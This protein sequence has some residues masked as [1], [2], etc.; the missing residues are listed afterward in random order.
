M[1]TFFEPVGG[2]C[3]RMTKQGQ[4][5]LIVSSWRADWELYTEADAQ[6][7]HPHFT[8]LQQKLTEAKVSNYIFSAFGH[9]SSR[10]MMTIL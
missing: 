9:G 1:P 10:L 2:G 7:Q 4:D 8:L 3:C 5:N 6:E